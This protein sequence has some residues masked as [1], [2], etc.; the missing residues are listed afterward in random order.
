[1]TVINSLDKS[2]HGVGLLVKALINGVKMVMM[3]LRVG[4]RGD[5]NMPWL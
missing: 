2:M 3:M 5:N 4:Q 1:M